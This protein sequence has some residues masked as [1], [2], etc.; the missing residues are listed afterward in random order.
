MGPGH[1][2]DHRDPQPGG[3]PR[4]LRVR[5]RP[6]GR[7]SGQRFHHRQLHVP[8]GRRRLRRCLRQQEAQGHRHPRHQVRCRCGS[9]EDPGAAAV[10]AARAHR[11][12][13][14]PCAAL[15]PA[16]L[17]RVR[18]RDALA[19]R[20]RQDVGRGHRRPAGHRRAE[21]GRHQRHRHAQPHHQLL[22]GQRRHRLQAHRED[23]RLP[24]LPDPLLPG[25]ALRCAQGVRHPVQHR[26]LHDPHACGGLLQRPH[27]RFRGSGRRP[28]DPRLPHP[29]A[30]GR[31]RR[32]VRL[33]RSGL[34][35]LLLHEE[36]HLQAEALRRGVR[37]DPVASAGG[38]RS[39]VG[40]RDGQP[41]RHQEGRVRPRA[42]HGLPV[43]GQGVGLPGF[44][45]A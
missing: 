3:R 29:V 16:E 37:R 10:S 23:R 13:Q 6:G 33:R 2:Q 21:A 27:Q 30:D 44:L 25:S 34:H 32:L 45:L 22:H 11:R 18:R 31:L 8:R 4:V 7:E 28:A 43:D 24:F 26:D 17:E 38:G 42:G 40:Q 35:L 19:G 39:A 36:R 20:P 12:Q 41:H 5:H 1:P 14:Q 15:Q 9:D